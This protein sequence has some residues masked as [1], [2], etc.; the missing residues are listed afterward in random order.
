MAAEAP[1]ADGLPEPA[2]WTT[3]AAI[4]LPSGLHQSLMTVPSS[5][6]R[7]LPVVASR[8]R[9]GPTGMSNDPAVASVGPIEATRGAVGEKATDAIPNTGIVRS[10]LPSRF[11]VTTL[12]GPS[13]VAAART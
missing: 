12:D 9:S 6:V 1:G 7:A 8:T 4:V 13:A 5:R 2:G 11:A 3:I 10:P